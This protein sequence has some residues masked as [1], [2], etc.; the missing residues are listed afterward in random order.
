MVAVDAYQAYRHESNEY[1]H[2]DRSV[3]SFTDFISQLSRQLIFNEHVLKRSLR[4]DARSHGIDEAFGD[5]P[6]YAEAQKAGKRVQRQCS[7]CHKKCSYYCIGCSDLQ[8]QSFFGVCGPRSQR[9]CF[10]QFELSFH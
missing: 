6:Q 9:T 3:P 7:L 5:L 2:F 4:S 1:H 10:C 8:L